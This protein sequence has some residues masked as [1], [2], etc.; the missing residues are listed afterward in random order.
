M[1]ITEIIMEVSTED[2][3]KIQSLHARGQGKLAIA[4]TQELERGLEWD[5]ATEIA[6][7]NLAGGGSTSQPIAAPKAQPQ[8][9]KAAPVQQAPKGRD[10]QDVAGRNLKH[11]RY[12][13]DKPRPSAAAAK[14]KVQRDFRRGAEIADRFM[15]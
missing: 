12:Y 15:Q 5:A 1:K 11:D 4:I 6:R 2:R 9:P 7:Q 8:Q 14:T 10:R 3:A 13:N